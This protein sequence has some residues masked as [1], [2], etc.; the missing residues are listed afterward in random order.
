MRILAA[1]EIYPVRPVYA[2]DESLSLGADNSYFTTDDGFYLYESQT[3]NKTADLKMNRNTAIQLVSASDISEILVDTPVETGVVG[4]YMIYVSDTSNSADLIFALAV[5][6][7]GQMRVTYNINSNQD[8]ICFFTITT[9]GD[10]I[11]IRRGVD[12]FTSV[13]GVI[14]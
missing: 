14:Q 8:E 1:S 13:D 11:E 7:S 10:K 6:V 12:G 5:D 2:W 4:N 3:M 9:S